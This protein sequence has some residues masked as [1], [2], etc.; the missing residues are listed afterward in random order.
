MSNRRR[1]A[2]SAATFAAAGLC[3]DSRLFQKSFA[4]SPSGFD[5]ASY[6]SRRLIGDTRSSA[7]GG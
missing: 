2:L 5:L 6:G 7:W 1:L 3:L 4:P